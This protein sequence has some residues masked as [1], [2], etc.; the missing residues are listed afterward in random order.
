M[1]LLLLLTAMVS[2]T[3]RLL[4]D[5]KTSILKCEYLINPVGIDVQ[6]PR[7]TWRMNDN[8]RGTFQTAYQIIVGTDSAKVRVGIGDQW[9]T[10]KTS[11]GDME[12]EYNGSPLK[13]FT[14]YFWTIKIWDTWGLPSLNTIPASFETG[15]PGT[16]NL[17]RGTL[18]LET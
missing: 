12:A 4:A 10:D 15:M 16:W 14:H 9:T 1:Y 5:S 17:E 2:L 13:P 7:L 11:S 6:H 3:N 18:N 8:R